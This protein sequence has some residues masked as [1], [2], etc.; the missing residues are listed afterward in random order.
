MRFT[1]TL[2]LIER[3]AYSFFEIGKRVLQSQQAIQVITLHLLNV[4]LRVEHV[5]KVGAAGAI[6]FLHHSFKPQRCRQKRAPVHLYLCLPRRPLIVDHGHSAGHCPTRRSYLTLEHARGGKRL[7]DLALVARKDR[8]GH[9]KLPASSNLQPPGSPGDWISGTCRRVEIHASLDTQAGNAFGTQT[10]EPRLF[11]VYLLCQ[12]HEVC[13]GAIRPRNQI[14]KTECRWRSLQRSAKVPHFVTW[15][16]KEQ[17]QITR[18]KLFPLLSD[19][20]FC[21]RARHFQISL[22]Y[23]QLRNVPRFKPR[24]RDLAHAL[25]QRK[26]ILLVDSSAV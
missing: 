6:A 3:P 8:H 18:G 20:K 12:M 17:I 23:F 24:L 1:P 10:S 16:I 25:C 13:I 19:D 15:L 21:L 5:E 26:C 11:H 9:G 7:R 14:I 22:E 2:L 4:T